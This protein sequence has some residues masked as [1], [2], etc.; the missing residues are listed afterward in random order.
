MPLF[1]QVA[2]VVFIEPHF[3]I[4]ELGSGQYLDDN[5]EDV[6]GCTG[7][8]EGYSDEDSDGYTDEDSDEDDYDTKVLSNI[9][10]IHGTGQVNMAREMRIIMQGKAQTMSDRIRMLNNAGLGSAWSNVER[11]QLDM[12]H[13]MA[14]FMEAPTSG[15]QSRSMRALNRL[16]SRALPSLREISFRGNGIF[17]MYNRIPIEGLIFERLGGPKPLRALKIESDCALFLEEYD[18]Y[19]GAPLALE[20]MCINCQDPSAN[21]ERPRVLASNLVELSF[22]TTS[23]NDIWDDFEVDGRDRSSR[24]E[25]SRLHS[26]NL[27][28]YM[29]LGLDS[30]M[31]TPDVEDSQE[32]CGYLKSPKYGKPC[33]PVL[34]SLDVRNFPHDYGRFLSLFVDSPISSLTICGEKECIPNDLDLSRFHGLC[35][36]SMLYFDNGCD[37]APGNVDAILSSVFVTTN[38]GLQ[39]LTLVTITNGLI[40]RR[41]RAPSFAH[42]LVTLTLGGEVNLRQVE[43]LLT[44]FPNLQ[45]LHVSA[46]AC[47]PLFSQSMIVREC[48]RMSTPRPLVPLNRSLR[49]LRAEHH[50]YFTS[51]PNWPETHN[52]PT[53]K[54]IEEALY[55]GLLLSLMCRL[56]SLDILLVNGR[57]IDAIEK[58]IHALVESGTASGHLQHLRI[59]SFSD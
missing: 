21:L 41:L 19:F 28:I 37:G 9:H 42:N 14:G 49:V 10:L 7:D 38:S 6:E 58:C 8:N 56:P 26:L 50:K 43:L 52:Y 53:A 29:D 55:R 39:Y 57:S 46:H 48:R 27:N 32:S 59:H 30:P 20:R 47:P 17:D 23:A 34:T 51:V 15:G 54:D 22:T 35:S 36:L 40:M 31:S 44:M 3:N 24:L 5:E 12:L 11:L 33:F 18:G 13:C 25:F 45:K 16:L 1:Y 2:A 4:D